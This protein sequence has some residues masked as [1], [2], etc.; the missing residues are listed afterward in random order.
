MVLICLS[1]D[2]LPIVNVIHITKVPDII[3][4]SALILGFILLI[5]IKFYLSLPFQKMSSFK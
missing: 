5:R 3:I 2:R 4:S 1:I